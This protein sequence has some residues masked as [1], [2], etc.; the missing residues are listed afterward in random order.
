MV[1]LAIE[2]GMLYLVGEGGG[3]EGRDFEI[4]CEILRSGL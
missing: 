1:Y 3:T 2:R 4:R